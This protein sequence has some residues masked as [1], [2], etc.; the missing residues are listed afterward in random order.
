[1]RSCA[2]RR[3]APRR[4]GR[5]IRTAGPAR[6]GAISSPGCA[7]PSTAA[8]ARSFS[9]AS[10]TTAPAEASRSRCS[11][12][13]PLRSRCRSSRAGARERP[14]TSRTRSPPARPPRSPRPSSTSARCRSPRSRKG[15]RGAASRC[16]GRWRTRMADE[17]TVDPAA[18]AYDA[19]GLVPAVVQD[20]RTGEVLMLAWQD[21]A[22][23]AQTLATGKATFFSRSRDALWVKG[24]T[25]GNTQTVRSVATDCDSDAI[26]LRVDPAG[27]ACHTGARSCFF[28]AVEA[29]V[30]SG[31]TAARAPNP[32][33]AGPIGQR[34]PG[35]TLAALEAVIRDR[36]TSPPPGSY[37]A[38]LFADEALRHKK[39]GEEATELV[40]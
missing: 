34:T 24:E 4:A 12:P 37:T 1:M 23:L 6:P 36:K 21:Q 32:P 35:E 3:A 18:I 33:G 29:K 19:R 11:A 27:P 26:L 25:S 13:S 30:P 39:V 17:Q 9:P 2:I 22:A 20:A 28:R 8:R 5:S 14:I 38:K 16:A 7:R 15:A 31:A 10:I 40:I